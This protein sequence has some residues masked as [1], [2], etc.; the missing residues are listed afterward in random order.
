MMAHPIVGVSDEACA[1]HHPKNAVDIKNDGDAMQAIQVMKNQPE[2]SE[3]Q[4]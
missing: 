1:L 4:Q 3:T 2:P